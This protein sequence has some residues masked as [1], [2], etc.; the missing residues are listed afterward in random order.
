MQPIL[1]IFLGFAVGCFGTLIGAGGG[2]VLMPVL[3]LL[4]PQKSP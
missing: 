2:F 3:L 1:L 4:Y